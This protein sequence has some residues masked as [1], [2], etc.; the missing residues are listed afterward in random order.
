MDSF[1]EYLKRERELRG[2]T[3]EEIAK[4]SNISKTYLKSLE[5][6]DFENLPSEVFV[7]GF[8]RCYAE[9]IG[10]DGNEATLAYSSFIADKR[11]SQVVSDFPTETPTKSNMKMSYFLLIVIFV[12]VSSLMVFYNV[13]KSREVKPPSVSENKISQVVDEIG[14]EESKNNIGITLGPDIKETEN[15]IETDDLETQAE[16]KDISDNLSSPPPTEIEETPETKEVTDIL[17]LSVEAKED[18]WI[19]LII[20]DAE[21]KEALLLPGETAKWKAKEK[22]VVTLG[23]AMGTHLKLNEKDIT[24]PKASSNIIK[25][26]T[27]TLDNINSQ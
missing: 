13:K 5:N 16:E 3:L 9:N 14:V 19:S 25:D 12:V 6:D 18:A 20:D 15:L 24:L 8:I 10:M 11:V 26:F 1:G 27:I 23:N 4:A 7:K 17:T 22:F 2:V 21:I